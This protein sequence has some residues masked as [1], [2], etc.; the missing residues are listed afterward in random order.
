MPAGSAEQEAEEAEKPA[1]RILSFFR[2]NSKKDLAAGAAGKSPSGD[3][4][5]PAPAAPPSP[6]ERQPSSSQIGIAPPS[7]APLPLDPTSP[8]NPTT[9]FPPRGGYK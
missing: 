4:A 3:I 6:I 9:P 8:Y 7:P 1:P 2:R 5:A